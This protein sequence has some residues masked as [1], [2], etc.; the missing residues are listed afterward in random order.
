[1]E[2]RPR[3]RPNPRLKYQTST[4]YAGAHPPLAACMARL[5]RQEVEEEGRG[6][7]CLG[8][9]LWYG[10]GADRD[11]YSLRQCARACWD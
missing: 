11:F 1:M 9:V 2:L 3:V 7:G 8:P 4:F 6:P 10:D 5:G